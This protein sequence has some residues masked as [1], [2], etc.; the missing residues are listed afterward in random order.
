MK[1]SIR[2][3]ARAFVLAISA[4]S[5]TGVGSVQAQELNPVVV[6]SNRVNEQLSDVL[7]SVSVIQKLDIDKFRYADLFELLSGQ[8][9][10]QLSRSGGAGNPTFVYMRGANSTQTLVLID[11][12]PF[13]SQ[14]AI[15]S[16]S[17]LEA[18][19]LAQVERVEILRGNASAV[20]GPGA[21]GGV[22][23]IFTQSPK[24]LTEGL[25]AKVEM[26]SMNSR[27]LQTSVRKNTGDG[28]LSLTIS[29]DRSDGISTM[30]PARY[31]SMP[32]V[33]INPD[34]NG[35]EARSLG[36]G[37]R[38]NLSASTQLAFQYL[39]TSTLAAYDNPYADLATDRWGSKSKLELAGGQV[40]HRVSEVWKTS[41]SY[42]QS[43]SKLG[44]LTNDVLNASYGTTH[45][46]QQQIKWD[47]LVALGNDTQAT[48]GYGNQVAKLE[49]GRTSYD[50]NVVPATPIDV[51][52]NKS[53]RQ[54]RLFGGVKQQVGAWSWRI[55]LSHEQLPG[56]QSEGTYLI[57]SG[58][59]LNRNYKITWTRS[60]AIQFPAVGQLF[61]VAYGGNANLKPEHSSSTE[62]GL[63]FKDDN[64]FWRLVAFDV[65]YKD[66]I[67]ASVNPVADP[68]WAAQY[69]TQLE[70]LSNAQNQGLEFAYARKWATSALQLA[71]TIQNPEN[72]SSSRPIQNRAKRFGSLTLSH[73]M[74][75][76]TSL[77]AK[78]L[79]TSAQ[80]TP[81][82][83]S[84]SSSALV[85][86]Y[87]VFNL[88]AD[89]KV[90]P[91]LKLTFSVLNVLDKTYFNLDGYNN[92]GRTYFMGL[93][94]AYR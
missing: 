73:F 70:N 93:K 57:G 92:P 50:W 87:A 38:Q 52:V 10:M 18:I 22:I 35:L 36:L 4:L 84:F 26:G 6:V 62:V 58:Y 1:K 91:D 69:V 13:A 32:L 31:A 83:G 51:R 94:Y 29:E 25:D 60:T 27:A 3:R 88:S 86:G 15:G 11:G 40:S 46:H 56:S 33:R 19:P 66:M 54:E 16:S 85:P 45:S 41:L 76:R 28:Q 80:W 9:G 72:T 71:Y 12:I 5:L 79:A 48:F 53:V 2:L 65:K 37:W 82:I 74:N 8:P 61:D 47:N 34:R 64:S 7:P 24:I 21:A 59:E 39:N 75:E 90:S 17:P 77:N 67:A 81:M 14:G 89:H 42:G 55:N 78:L 49:A 68:F 63:Q 44:T 43:I 30:T 23:Q 20:Y